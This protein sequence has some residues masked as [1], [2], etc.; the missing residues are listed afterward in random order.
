MP[1]K[2]FFLLLPH[3]LPQLTP[4]WQASRNDAQLFSL[5]PTSSRG[6]W[7]GLITGGRIF[8]R[9]IKVEPARFLHANVTPSTF[10][11][12]TYFVGRYFETI[13]YL[14]PLQTFDLFI[15]IV[16]PV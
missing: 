2:V 7:I 10:V 3:D 12:N 14:V 11:I 5:Q 6:V 13:K 4:I 8:E 9:L 16:L 1:I 15:C